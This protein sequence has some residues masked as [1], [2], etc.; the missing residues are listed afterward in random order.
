M[1]TEERQSSQPV[2]IV[3][4]VYNGYEDLLLCVGSLKRHTDLTRHR[5][6]LIDDKS[7]DGRIR[8][9][10]EREMR[11]PGIWVLFN[12]Q[13]RGFSANVNT[14]LAYSR[15]DTI[16]LNSDTIVTDRWVE[17]LQRCADSSARIATVTPLSNAATL[18][19]VPEFLNGR[20]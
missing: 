16:L 3:V 18:A 8:P 7:T 20:L 10:L 17:K 13:N 5:V 19:S 4:P 1:K 12:D 6:I 11:C 15:R 14:G 2:D 9:Y